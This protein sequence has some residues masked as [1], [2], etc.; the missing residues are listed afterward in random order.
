MTK[1]YEPVRL[2]TDDIPAKH[3]NEMIRDFYGKISMRME[4]EAISDEPIRFTARTHVLPRTSVSVGAFTAVS[5]ERTRE[6]VSDGNDDVFISHGSGGYHASLNGS[7]VLQATSSEAVL[8][9]LNHRTRFANPGSFIRTVQIKRSLIAPLVWSIDD[10]PARVLSLHRPEVRLL[11]HYI[12][13]LADADLS[14]PELQQMVST[15]LS[16]LAS[17]A[18]GA[19]A[20]AMEVARLG[21]VRAAR[22]QQ[23]L[24]EIKAGYTNPAFSTADIAVKLG[25]S[26]RYIQDLLHETGSTLSARLLELRL[27]KAHAMLTERGHLEWRVSA[28]AFAC[29]FSDVPYFNQCFRRRFGMTPSDVRAG[30]DA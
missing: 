3:R 4:I 19:K 7:E 26:P 1:T 16:D 24:S 2:S 10:P 28:I 5:G 25:V 30:R 18:I 13:G 21:G 17:L 27:R 14:S 6:L 15:H 12:D 23:V 9:S 22:L 8:T 29:G 20:D 11:F